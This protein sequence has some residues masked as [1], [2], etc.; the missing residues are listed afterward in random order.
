MLIPFPKCHFFPIFFLFGSS[1][2]STSSETCSEAS[3]FWVGF[4]DRADLKG[5]LAGVLVGVLRA[6]FFFVAGLSTLSFDKG[7]T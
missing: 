6:D 1:D 2:S 7:K 3:R 4:L 5:V